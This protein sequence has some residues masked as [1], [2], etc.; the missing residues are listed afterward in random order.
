VSDPGREAA[1]NPRIAVDN[2]GYLHVVWTV[3]AAERSWQGKAVYYARS[4]DEGRTWQVLEVSRSL[5]EESTT[6]W[7]GV[8]V[9]LGDEI[10]LAWNRGIGSRWG[11]YHSWSPDNGLTWSEPA[12]FLAEFVS[13]QTQWP[14]MV[15]DSAGTLHLVTVAGG[16]PPVA[17]EG[18]E[19]RPRYA[20]WH[21]SAWSEMLTFPES[22]ADLNVALAIGRGHQLH[23]IHENGRFA[24]RLLY[25][26]RLTGAP[27]LPA[28]QIPD[29]VRGIRPQAPGPTPQP[30][31]GDTPAPG[32]QTVDLEPLP[33]QIAG[34][35]DPP[36]FLLLPTALVLALLAAVVAW[37]L[38]R[39]TRS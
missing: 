28:Q 20:Y 12:P 2:K 7:I 16:P 26:A 19:D 35:G 5:P 32:V 33:A 15:E 37:R 31:P 9:R 22:S 8:A 21:G 27:P 3:N 18:F 13:G 36:A 1:T 34:P 6:G 10:H 23:L 25:T 24:G 4:T 11:R 29:P 30:A 38:R 39:W 14:L 17:G